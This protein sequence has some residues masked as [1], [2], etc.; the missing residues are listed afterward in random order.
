MMKIYL[1]GSSLVLVVVV[2]AGIMS[3]D[4]SEGEL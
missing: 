3:T 1:R 2:M 4:F